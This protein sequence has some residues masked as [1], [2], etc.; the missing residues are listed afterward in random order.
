M[1]AEKVS[2]YQNFFQNIFYHSVYSIKH[3]DMTKRRGLFDTLTNEIVKG[4]G[5]SFGFGLGKKALKKV[6][7]SI[8]DSSSNFRKQISKLQ[9]SGL[10]GTFKS[11]ITKMY[12]ILDGFY[13]EYTTSEA[14][15]QHGTYKQ[16]DINFIEQKIDF[17]E[18]FV[19]SE[20]EERAYH[21]LIN[22]WGE[23]RNK[24]Q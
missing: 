20:A 8:L 16:S 22:N 2:H 1:S 18:R 11:S 10:P 13:T 23:I 21:R 15:L 17:I 12:S 3:T 4:T 24:V 6:E 5:R 14:L 19:T 7:T 9:A